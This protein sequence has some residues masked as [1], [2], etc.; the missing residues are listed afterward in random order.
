MAW[1]SMCGMPAQRTE[2]NT[3]TNTQEVGGQEEGGV[4]EGPR[5]GQVGVQ[6]KENEMIMPC[7]ARL[8]MNYAVCS[9]QPISVQV[10]G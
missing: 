10:R 3:K 9:C 8:I 4:Q 1:R 7:A 6:A 5:V 2:T